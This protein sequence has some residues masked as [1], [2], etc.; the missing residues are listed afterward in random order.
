[1]VDTHFPADG[2]IRQASLAYSEGSQSPSENAMQT[3]SPT[4]L[5]VDFP[6]HGPW[7]QDLAEQLAPFAVQIAA[8]PGLQW[9]LWTENPDACRA[10]GP[11]MASRPER[12]CQLSISSSRNTF[13]TMSGLGQFRLS[14][15]N[16]SRPE[17]H[18]CLIRYHPHIARRRQTWMPGA[19]NITL[20][21]HE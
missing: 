7:G 5:T 20:P 17:G 13:R 21:V 16:R 10:G 4:L 3:P 18:G 11:I 6:F 14:A 12:A 1:M 8:A 19:S 2:L 9:K 15:L